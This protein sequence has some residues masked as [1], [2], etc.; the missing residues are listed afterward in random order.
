LTVAVRET[1]ETGKD[2]GSER[3]PMFGP[4]VDVDDCHLSG[5]VLNEKRRGLGTVH[6]STSHDQSQINRK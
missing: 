6:E 1:L 5:E 2:S 4:V 3:H